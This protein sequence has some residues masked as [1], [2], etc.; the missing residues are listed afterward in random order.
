MESILCS[1]L[2]ER[3][4]IPS[5]LL[6]EK[7]K[8]SQHVSMK[9]LVLN[10]ISDRNR[11]AKLQVG[12]KWMGLWG[13]RKGFIW[14]T[15]SYNSITEKTSQHRLKQEAWKQVLKQESCLLAWS[16]QLSQPAFY[17]TQD[18]LPRDSTIYSGLDSPTAIVNQEQ[19][20]LQV[21]LMLEFPQHFLFLGGS[22]LC[23]VDKHQQQQQQQGKYPAYPFNDKFSRSLKFS[24]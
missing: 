7:S 20:C 10:L 21:N 9:F 13:E 6:M 14:L 19:T 8:Y 15:W 4:V 18:H 17:R 23:E 12:P 24:L 16:S 11:L 1:V 3:L 2:S 22:S 5:L